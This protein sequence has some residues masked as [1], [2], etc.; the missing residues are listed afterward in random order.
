MMNKKLLL[1]REQ[2]FHKFLEL[3]NQNKDFIEISNGYKTKLLNKCYQRL[4][5]AK[6]IA[7]IKLYLK[8]YDASLYYADI[9]NFI[10]GRMS[11]T[12]RAYNHSK[13]IYYKYIGENKFIISEIY[14]DQKLINL[15]KK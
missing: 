2:N 5:Y 11:L 3:Y 12:V 15:N 10:T 1:E 13:Y 7:A 9:N 14:A 6:C 8:N 4:E